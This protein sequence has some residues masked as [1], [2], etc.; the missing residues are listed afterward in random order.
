MVRRVGEAPAARQGE[1]TRLTEQA[2]P[3]A[4]VPGRVAALLAGALRG[5]QTRVRT[6]AAASDRKLRAA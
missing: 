1:R 2:G 3:L 4:L 6:A 5:Q